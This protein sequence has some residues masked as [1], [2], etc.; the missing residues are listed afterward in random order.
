MVLQ[1][2]DQLQKMQAQIQEQQ[3]LLQELQAELAVVKARLNRS[4]DNQV[5]V[6]KLQE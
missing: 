5:A 4:D 1:K 2:D 6:L 3:A